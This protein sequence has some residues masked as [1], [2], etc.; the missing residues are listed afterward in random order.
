M[1]TLPEF[2]V[3]VVT[4]RSGTHTV[5][6]EADDASAARRL[7]ESDCE[8]NQCHCPP[9]WCT[10]DV[11]SDVTDVR[12]VVLDGVTLISAD[13]A[14]LGTLHGSDSLRRIEAPCA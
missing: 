12:P 14:G 8:V 9:E 11:D 13:G 3:T 5:R 2:E 4:F 7:V 6:V 10:D 1:T